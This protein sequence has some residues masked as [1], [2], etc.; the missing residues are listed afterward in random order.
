MVPKDKII[1]NFLIELLVL[2]RGIFKIEYTVINQER[3]L[4]QNLMS[5]LPLVDI[6]L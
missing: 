2:T 1:S 6:N 3:E 4:K 5:E